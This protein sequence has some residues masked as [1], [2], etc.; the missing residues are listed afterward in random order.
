MALTS[1]SIPS[2]NFK[3]RPSGARLSRAL[4]QESAA[5]TIPKPHVHLQINCLYI[6]LLSKLYPQARLQSSNPKSTYFSY[7]NLLS[8]S[9]MSAPWVSSFSSFPRKCSFSLSHPH[10]VPY[11]SAQP[12]NGFLSF[13]EFSKPQKPLLGITKPITGRDGF[14]MILVLMGWTWMNSISGCDKVCKGM[15]VNACF[16]IAILKHYETNTSC[17]ILCV[18]ICSVELSFLRIAPSA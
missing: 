12:L 17:Y 10:N 11:C 1:S 7:I 4:W 9:S 18:F 15:Q 14:Q 6:K 3:F 13:K 5:Q 2:R 16:R 8:P